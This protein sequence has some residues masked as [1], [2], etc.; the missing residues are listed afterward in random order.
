MLSKALAWPK[1]IT[2]DESKKTLAWSI[3][4]NLKIERPSVNENHQLLSCSPPTGLSG[5]SAD[6]KWPVWWEQ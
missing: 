1:N 2:K 5:F 4:K 3:F 6:S